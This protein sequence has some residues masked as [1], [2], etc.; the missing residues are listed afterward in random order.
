MC[1]NVGPKPFCWAK[2][3]RFDFSSSNFD[4]QGHILNI[5]GVVLKASPP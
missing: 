2:P 4:F 5:S 3:T 1:K